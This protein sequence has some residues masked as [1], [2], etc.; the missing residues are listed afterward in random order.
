MNALARIISEFLSLPVQAMP[1]AEYVDR[2]AN[3]Y[4]SAWDSIRSII[5]DTEDL[6]WWI[7]GPIRL[8]AN[9]DG[10]REGI[11]ISND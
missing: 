9:R 7:D 2:E 4:A 11:I 1:G 10:W 6:S 5:A 8:S 3:E